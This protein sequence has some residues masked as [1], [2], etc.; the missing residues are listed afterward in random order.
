MFKISKIILLNL[1]KNILDYKWRKVDKILIQKKKLK[2]SVLY[3]EI[4]NINKLKM[5]LSN[6]ININKP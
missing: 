5:I 2:K 3:K 4:K 6:I 1:H